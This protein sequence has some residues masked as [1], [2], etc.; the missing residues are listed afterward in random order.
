MVN[1]EELAGV[2]QQ[3]LAL[4]P[5]DI[6]PETDKDELLALMVTNASALPM[7]CNLE[8]TRFEKSARQVLLQLQLHGEVLLCYI[9]EVHSLPFGC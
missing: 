9:E 3:I 8:P 2:K 1:P 7:L 4:G 6:W 5:P